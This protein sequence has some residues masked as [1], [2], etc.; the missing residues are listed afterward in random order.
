MYAFRQG[1]CDDNNLCTQ[2]DRCSDGSCVGELL[3]CDDD[4]DCTIDACSSDEGCVFIGNDDACSDQQPCT[5]DV[6]SD[7]GCTNEPAPDYTV[8]GE[9][10]SC[11][12]AEVCI[13]QA[14]TSIE[15]PDGVPCSD[16]DA[17]TIDDTCQE[18]FCIGEVSEEPPG[19]VE[20]RLLSAPLTRNVLRRGDFFF[21]HSTRAIEFSEDTL[22]PRM[23]PAL[24]KA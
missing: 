19:I 10:E 18:G 8:C 20:T 14:C 1:P 2:D 16:N 21:D 23:I 12:A 3:E 17:C 4:V 5:L 13:A 7:T 9:I 6:C 22:I 24:A 15:I 11:V